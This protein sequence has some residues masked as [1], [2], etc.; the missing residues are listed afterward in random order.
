MITRRIADM[1]GMKLTLVRMKCYELGL[2]RMELQYWT[3]EQVDFLKR[4]YAKYGDTELAEMFSYAWEKEKGWSK[5]HIEKKRRYLGLKRTDEEKRAIHR[6]NVEIGCFSM[7]PVKAWE[8]RGI[9]N[10]G[11]VR[12]WRHSGVMRMFIKTESGFV[13]YPP[14]LWEQHFGK[15]PE[16]MVVALKD[17]N[18]LN[19]VIDNL[20]L[21]SRVTMMDR[22]TIHRYP[23]ELKSVIMLLSKLKKKID[24]KQTA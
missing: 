7:C 13:H 2:K 10:I 24:E 22:N 1:L 14:Y 5:K 23:D 16:G 12:A 4:N 15:P 9:A 8:Q 17:G 18:P 3:D 20:E 19:V 21:Q 6:R 11:E